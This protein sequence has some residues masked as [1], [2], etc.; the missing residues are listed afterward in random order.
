MLNRWGRV[1]SVGLFVTQS[2]DGQTMTEPV[3]PRARDVGIVVGILPTGK[4]NAI[5]DVQGVKVGQTT[6]VRGD[7]IRTGVTAI[8]PH[9]GNLFQEK[10]PGA[11]VVGNGFGKFAPVIKFVCGFES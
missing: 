5:T 6:L 11:I 7:D 8:L 4:L 9:D 1:F 10:V 2:L 3:R